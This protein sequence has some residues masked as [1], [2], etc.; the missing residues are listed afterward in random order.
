MPRLIAS[1]SS[2]LATRRNFWPAKRGYYFCFFC[3]AVLVA[4]GVISVHARAEV[5][6][7]RS[8]RYTVVAEFVELDDDSVVLKNQTGKT[9]RVPLASLSEESRSQA[10]ELAG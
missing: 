9:I 3:F 6:A 7:D 5:W 2:L 1:A 4:S 8:G 10:N